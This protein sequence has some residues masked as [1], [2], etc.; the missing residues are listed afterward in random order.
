[1]AENNGGKGIL[2]GWKMREAECHYQH[3]SMCLG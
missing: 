3:Q 1:M 2:L